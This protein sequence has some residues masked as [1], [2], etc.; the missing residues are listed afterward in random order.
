MVSHVPF[1]SKGKTIFK[2]LIM[3]WWFLIQTQ[4]FCKE[5]MRL[6]VKFNYLW[7]WCTFTNKGRLCCIELTDG[8]LT[9]KHMHVSVTTIVC[10]LFIHEFYH[11]Q[12]YRHTMWTS[13]NINCGLIS[14]S[15]CS[16]TTRRHHDYAIL[17]CQFHINKHYKQIQSR[18]RNV[19]RILI[20][21]R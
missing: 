8:P 7:Q 6:G 2:F 18:H 3:S 13:C 20:I 11:P 21:S 17:I 19:I 4:L 14:K 15:R 12:Q 5:K 1:C 10:A 16:T 9:G